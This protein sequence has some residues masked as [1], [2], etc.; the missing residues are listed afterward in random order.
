MSDGIEAKEN[1]T[2]LLVFERLLKLDLGAC[3]GVG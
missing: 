3:I 1:P 2:K